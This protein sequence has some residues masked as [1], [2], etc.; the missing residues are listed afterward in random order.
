MTDLAEA[1]M[2]MKDFDL[3]WD[4]VMTLPRPSRP[5]HAVLSGMKRFM[6]GFIK[7]QEEGNIDEFR[8][9]LDKIWLELQGLFLS[10]RM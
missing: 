1:N 3:A 6:N 9:P 4:G 2:A 8:R 5:G 10:S 7:I